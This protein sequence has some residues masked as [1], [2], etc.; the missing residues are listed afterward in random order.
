MLRTI[1][2]VVETLRNAKLRGKKC[3]VLIGAGCS[4]TAGIPTAQGFVDIIRQPER[5]PRAYERAKEKHP[6][7][8]TSTSRNWD[9]PEVVTLNHTRKNKEQA[10]LELKDA[11]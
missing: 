1:E 7:R 11:A 4:V 6:E 10:I 3:S 9:R 2:D 8:W 5:Y